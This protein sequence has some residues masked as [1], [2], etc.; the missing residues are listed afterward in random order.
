MLLALRTRRREIG[1]VV[2]LLTAALVLVLV[3]SAVENYWTLHSQVLAS[4]G[5]DEC[6]LDAFG[7]PQF[8]GQETTWYLLFF[9]P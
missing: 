8:T 2:L 4:L 5:V 1:L 6:F 7:C 3:G 9:H